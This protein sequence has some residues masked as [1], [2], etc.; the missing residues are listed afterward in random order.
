VLVV[1]TAACGSHPQD[2]KIAGHSPAVATPGCKTRVP[3][4]VFSAPVVQG[5]ALQALERTIGIRGSDGLAVQAEDQAAIYYRTACQRT[6]AAT[7]PDCRLELATLRREQG[8]WTILARSEVREGQSYP[9]ID[10]WNPGIVAATGLGD[11][12]GEQAVFSAWMAVGPGCDV[13]LE[14]RAFK[15]LA[16]RWRGYVVGEDHMP[17]GCVD[18]PI[19]PAVLAKLVKF[20]LQDV[21][22]DGHVDLVHEIDDHSDVYLFAPRTRTFGRGEEFFPDGMFVDGTYTPN[23]PV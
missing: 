12:G 15:D 6:D 5:A 18:S 14:L 13:E 16:V 20:S 4:A 21:N 17:P 3:L 1:W 22:C 23:P 11:I 19:A 10:P 2:A 8:G 9:S 7:P